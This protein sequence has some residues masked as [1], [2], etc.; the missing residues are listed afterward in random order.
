M[1]LYYEHDQLLH[2]VKCPVPKILVTR[3]AIIN[4]GYR[5]SISHC[6]PRALKTDAPLSLLWD[7]VRTVVCLVFH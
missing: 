1:P 2:I 7:I 6:N 3:S 5:C 4:A